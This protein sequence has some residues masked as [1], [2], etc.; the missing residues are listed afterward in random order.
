MLIRKRP[1]LSQEDFIAYYETN[2]LELI[3]RLVGGRPKAYRRHYA[4][5]DAGLVHRL[6][7]GRGD[8]VATDISAVTELTFERYEDAEEM[9]E[10]MLA[11]DVLPRVL[12]DEGEFIDRDGITWLMT[13][14]LGKD[15]DGPT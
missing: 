2:H 6:A 3:G 9:V 5:A 12:A 8:A 14:R 15:A 4:V 13:T 1:E 11:D 10:R 7:D